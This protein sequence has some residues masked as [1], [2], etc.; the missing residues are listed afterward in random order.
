M[1]GNP[2]SRLANPRHLLSGLLESGAATT[3]S[4]CAK[5]EQINR[6][7]GERVAHVEADR[8]ELAEIKKKIITKMSVIAVF[9]VPVIGG[10]S[11][12]V[13]ALPSQAHGGCR[14]LVVDRLLFEA[15]RKMAR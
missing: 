14:L 3:N 8:K 9:R 10:A 7:N 1:I 12:S 4:V 15:V 6:R 2:Q 5:S 13:Y 11:H